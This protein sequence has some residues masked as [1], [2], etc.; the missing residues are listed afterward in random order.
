MDR[1][2][3]KYYE[4]IIQLTA[5]PEW[6]ELVKEL[7][8][9]IYNIQANSLEAPSWDV[10]CESRGFAK[11]LAYLVNLREDTKKQMQIEV[12]NDAAV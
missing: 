2:N 12:D 7:E 4:Q 5:Y 8:K 3:S 6:G 11:G 10:V 1:A 9:M